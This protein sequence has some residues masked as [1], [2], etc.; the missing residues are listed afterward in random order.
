MEVI[1]CWTCQILIL[2][3]VWIWEWF[4]LVSMRLARSIIRGTS[5]ESD[6]ES[7]Q[8]HLII[9]DES[10]CNKIYEK[11]WSSILVPRYRCVSVS[12]SLSIDGY[13][14][15]TRLAIYSGTLDG[16]TSLTISN[17]PVL[18]EVLFKRE[19]NCNDMLSNLVR[20]TIS[21]RIFYISIKLIFL[22]YRPFTWE[23]IVSIASQVF[24]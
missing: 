17:D 2:I 9:E 3:W 20:L 14:N 8:D 4:E 18:T 10:D 6:Q 7:N 12:G 1:H 21:S 24:R 19:Y 15:L 13:S 11:H 22:C 5:Y 23:N 16:L